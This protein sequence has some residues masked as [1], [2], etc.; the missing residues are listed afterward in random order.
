M[1]RLKVA[2]DMIAD[3][4]AENQRLREALQ[5]IERVSGWADHDGELA[6]RSGGAMTD[7]LDLADPKV[8]EA[9][10]RHVKLLRPQPG[11]ILVIKGVD[12]PYDQAETILADLKRN[13]GDI[14]ALIFES[15]DASAELVQQAIRDR[16]ASD[17][18][19]R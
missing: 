10:G 19:E 2:Q 13:V 5:R 15:A 7:W 9:I 4:I 1:T 6:G 8:R 16:V 17:E 12:F 11:D 14:P 3:L 18:G